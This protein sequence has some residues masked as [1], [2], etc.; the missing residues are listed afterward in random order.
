MTTKFNVILNPYRNIQSVLVVLRGTEHMSLVAE[1][2]CT[3]ENITA[4]TQGDFVANS[5]KQKLIVF[6]NTALYFTA[7][8]FFYF[9]AL[10]SRY[11]SMHTIDIRARKFPDKFTITEKTP[12]RAFS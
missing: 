11:Q 1:L 2:L 3:R 8:T 4:A 7:L 12:T 10:Q 6:I 9:S 5:L